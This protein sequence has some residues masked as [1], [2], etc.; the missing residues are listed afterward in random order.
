MSSSEGP[1]RRRRIAGESAP[2]GTA[3][4][5][6]R[7][8]GKVSNPRARSAGAKKPAPAKPA[9]KTVAARAKVAKAPS[10]QPGATKAAET[11]VKS[12]A[13]TTSASASATASKV[14]TTSEQP[15]STKPSTRASAQELRWFVP[16]ALLA[17]VALVLGSVLLAKGISD[18]RGGGDINAAQEAAAKT[19]SAAAE[20][21]FS[22]RYDKLPDHLAG[23]K[24]TM[25]PAFA[26]EFDKIAP[27]LTDLAPQRKI[28]VQAATRNA[29]AVD[30]GS[31][32]S[33]SKATILVFVDQ[34]RLVSGSDQPTVF[35]NRIKVSMVKTNGAWLVSDIR[36]L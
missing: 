7:A 36:A 28:V 21:I 13:A 4:E 11:V 17:I 30:C 24:A 15:D 29:A 12:P 16:A 31:S 22:F 9:D 14:S 5:S 2:G 1:V 8:K 35:G 34:A 18:R 6:P 20:T 25:T 32:C 26:K 3:P 23:A 19:A 10:K 27:A 33:T